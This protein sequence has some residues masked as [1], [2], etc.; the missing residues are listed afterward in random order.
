V[1][2]AAREPDQ[3]TDGSKF[4]GSVAL[5]QALVYR[6]VA[7]RELAARGCKDLRRSGLNYLIPEWSLAH[8]VAAP[9]PDRFN[10]PARA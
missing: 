1:A 2:Q 10:C 7:I 9:T 8:A 4:G 5:A 6:R 3:I